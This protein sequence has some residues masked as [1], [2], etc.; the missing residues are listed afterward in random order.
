M[1]RFGGSG[2]ESL[3]LGGLGFGLLLERRESGVQTT[4]PLR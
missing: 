2:G 1:R 3:V 4:E